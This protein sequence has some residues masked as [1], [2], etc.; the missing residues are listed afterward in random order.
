MTQ[1]IEARFNA[2]AEILSGLTERERLLVQE[3]AVMGYVQGY[4]Q[5]MRHP[6]RPD[7]PGDEQ[8]LMTIVDACLGFP[9]L[10]PTIT[11]R[12]R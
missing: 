3:V 9:D 6:H 4:A 5:G 1:P 2:A 10:Y 12:K 8:I 11:A 7:C